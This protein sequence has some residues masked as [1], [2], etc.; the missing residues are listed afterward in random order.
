MTTIEPAKGKV[1]L[2]K[3]SLGD[4]VE[5]ELSFGPKAILIPTKDQAGFQLTIFSSETGPGLTGPLVIMRYAFDAAIKG[6]LEY[7]QVETL[8]H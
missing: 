4:G 3:P 5:L 2:D 1:L 6:S 8:R 7:L